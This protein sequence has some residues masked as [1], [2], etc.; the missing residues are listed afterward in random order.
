MRKKRKQ[1]TPQKTN[2]R[3][4]NTRLIT[5]FLFTLKLSTFSYMDFTEDEL[6]LRVHLKQPYKNVDTSTKTAIIT[7]TM[8]VKGTYCN[9]S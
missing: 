8:L 3:L 4:Q 5:S 7:R 6:V 9:E 2:G 1:Q